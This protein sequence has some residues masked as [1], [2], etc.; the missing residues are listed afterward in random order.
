MPD[1]RIASIIKENLLLAGNFDSAHN[2]IE[3]VLLRHVLV[4]Y[5]SSAS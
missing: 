1:I 5:G 4:M 2:G 3:V